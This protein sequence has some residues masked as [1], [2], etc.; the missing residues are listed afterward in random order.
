MQTNALNFDFS[1]EENSVEPIRVRKRVR[2]K[3]KRRHKNNGRK[4]QLTNLQAKNWITFVA[5]ILLVIAFIAGLFYVAYHYFPE[6]ETP[7]QSQPAQT[8]HA[9]GLE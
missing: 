4:Q 1:G 5:I 9:L 8:T 7:P 2:V 6:A 3:S